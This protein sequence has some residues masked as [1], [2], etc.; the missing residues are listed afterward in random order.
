MVLGHTAEV[1]IV[2]I[3][4]DWLTLTSNR[5]GEYH[6]STLTN[7]YDVFGQ[8]RA[9][10]G[11]VEDGS[12]LGYVGLKTEGAFIGTRYDGAMIRLSGKV[13]RDHF[14]SLQAQSAAPTRIDVQV[15]CYWKGSGLHPPRHVVDDGEVIRAMDER[16]VWTGAADGTPLLRAPAIHD[17]FSLT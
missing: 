6:E 14:L 1:K 11:L 15:T 5:E 4:V 9:N 2:D 16:H 13:A 8:I 12:S 7:W 17:R 3:G 10:N